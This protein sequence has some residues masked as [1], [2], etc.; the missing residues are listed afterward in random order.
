[1][2]AFGGKLTD[3]NIRDVLSYIKNRQKNFGKSASIPNPD[4]CTVQP[5]TL[6]ELEALVGTTSG[7]APATGTIPTPA[8]VQL[9]SDPSVDTNT[10]SE[11]IQT[12]EQMVACTNAVDT[13]RRLA[14]F[15]DANL[16][17]SFPDGVTPSFAQMATQ[18]SA[19]LP[20]TKW[21]ALLDVQD[22]SMLRDGRIRATVIIDD[23]STHIHPAAVANGTPP[24]QDAYAQKATIVFVKVGDRWL[25]DQ[26]E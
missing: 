26:I 15:S 3:Q 25:I 14:L 12:V 7:Q 4:T 17:A 2:P 10:Q 21:M 23:P 24:A 11:V 9:A 20:Q 8:P 19:P 5:R 6:D 18:A 16:K 1:M 22:I 13:M